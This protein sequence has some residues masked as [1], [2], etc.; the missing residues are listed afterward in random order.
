MFDN[1]FDRL[2]W[3]LYLWRYVSRNL[4]YCDFN[5]NTVLVVPAR[6]MESNFRDANNCGFLGTRPH[7]LWTHSIGGS[8]AKQYE[9]VF[10][11]DPKYRAEETQRYPSGIVGS[12]DDFRL[13]CGNFVVQRRSLH[14]PS[15]DR[16]KNDG[17]SLGQMGDPADMAKVI[18]YAKNIYRNG[19]TAVLW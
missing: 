11:D 16:L 18:L 3:Q 17:L 12:M 14:I 1:I 8:N 9:L 2:F 5:G 4:W 13:F 19:R 6:I 7:R 10:S 15:P